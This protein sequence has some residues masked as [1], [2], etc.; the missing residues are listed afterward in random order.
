MGEAS[1][2]S[3]GLY[4]TGVGITLG[5]GKGDQKEQ[6]VVTGRF[7]L[8]TCYDIAVVWQMA[9]FTLVRGGSAVAKADCMLPG[10]VMSSLTAW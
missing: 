4:K 1:R 10:S 6:K 8:L 9:K 7:C 2:R 5:V 3:R